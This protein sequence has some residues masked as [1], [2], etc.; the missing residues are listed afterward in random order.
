[1]SGFG[2]G[3]AKVANA[4]WWAGALDESLD[5]AEVVAS[6]KLVEAMDNSFFSAT[7]L[8]QKG[9]TKGMMHLNL[10]RNHI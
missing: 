3:L 7:I 6:W 1:M 10:E 4:T 8:A 5:A 9:T 2:F